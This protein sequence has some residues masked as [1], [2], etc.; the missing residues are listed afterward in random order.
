M[1]V[2][3]RPIMSFAASRSLRSLAWACC[4]LVI[5]ATFGAGTARAQIGSD[6]YSS[7]VV[8]ASSGRVISSANPDELRHPASLTKL[9][10]LYMVFEAL[11]DRRI[12]LH[13]LVPVS[14]HAA[15]QMPSKL[16][17]VPGTKLTVEDAILGLVTKSAN[18]AAAA[19]G[20]M[21]G[22]EEGRFAQ[23]MTLRAR[24]L[25][26]TSTTFRNA[27]GLPDPG[28][29]TTARDLSLLARRLI[30]DFPDQYGYFSVP[31][32]RFHG[33]VIF[34]HDHMLERYPGADGLK[35]GYIQASGFNLVT[36]AVRGN[37]RL[38]GVVIGAAA[39]GERDL[40]M[41]ALLDEA[42]ARLDVPVATMQAS[43]RSNSFISTAHAATV[44]ARP[45]SS[46]RWSIQVGAFTTPQAARRAAIEA[47][48]AIDNGEARTE[49][50]TVRGKTSY[51]AQV[52]GLSQS[53]AANACSQFTR[54]RKPCI[55]LR[56]DQTQLASR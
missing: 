42:Y 47:V 43:A 32:F 21:L 50:V 44:T 54:R 9:M 11:R 1:G 51:R 53:E 37:I 20:E 55:T 23:M 49:P 22:G 3:N 34:N 5:A 2:E 25:G 56:M 27:S 48:H 30:R 18:D 15:A 6:R 26:M 31:S 38:V 19:L 46:G 24:A 4:L 14:S 28:Q 8:E 17:I 36:S 39:P 45:R 29:V 16:G 12:N 7:I 52:T 13:Q 35:T 33:R 40:H 10:T 41:I